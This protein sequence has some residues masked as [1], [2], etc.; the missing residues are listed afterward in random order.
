M[1]D[2]TLTADRAAMHKAIADMIKNELID[3]CE[4]VS[5]YM[6]LA[7]K[8]DATFPDEPYGEILR[9]IA[10]D[11]NKHRKY[12]MDILDDMNAL[13]PNDVKAAWEKADKCWEK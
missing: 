1:A 2:N 6:T 3:E 4:G 10:R 12:L 13:M 7:E 9:G 11:E 8:A 5:K